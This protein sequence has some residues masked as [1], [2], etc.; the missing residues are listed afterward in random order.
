VVALA[1]KVA[2]VQEEIVVI[3]G[4]TNVGVQILGFDAQI[5]EEGPFQA[6]ANRVTEQPIVVVIVVV[7]EEGHGADQKRIEVVDP[8][9]STIRKTACTISSISSCWAL[10]PMGRASSATTITATISS[11]SATTATTRAFSAHLAAPIGAAELIGFAAIASMLQRL[12]S[13]RILRSWDYIAIAVGGIAIVHP[14]SRVGAVV[15]TVLGLLFIFQSDRRR[16]SIGQLC[17]GLAW[18]DLWGPLVFR[19]IEPWFLPMETAVGYLP[20]SMFG[21][22]SLVGNAILSDAGHGVVVNPACSVFANTIRTTF[23]WLAMVKVQGTEF[24]SWHFRVL[25]LSLVTVFLLNTSRLGLMAYSYN[26]YLFWHES[27]GASIM[28]WTM[29]ATVIGLFCFGLRR[30]GSS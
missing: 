21:S 24:R 16:A 29:L 8:R 13:D 12:N 23:I 26:G 6:P 30:E 19:V 2:V 20:L 17:L 27:Y 4:A 3:V 5:I 15:L 9:A 10:R 11:T 14:W 1:E 18:L 28:S 22:F 25:A 7:E